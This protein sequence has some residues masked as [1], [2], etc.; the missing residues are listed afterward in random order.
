[1]TVECP[2]AGPPGFL[3]RIAQMLKSEAFITQPLYTQPLYI[4]PLYIQ[5]LYIQPLYTQPL[6]TLSARAGEPSRF[7]SR[8]AQMLV[9][10]QSG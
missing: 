1:M 5:S 6:C 8:V 4:Q 10:L 2:Q 3:S 9:A 7:L